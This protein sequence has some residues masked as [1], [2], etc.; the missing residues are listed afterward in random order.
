MKANAGHAEPGAGF[1]GLLKLV[2]GLS[3]AESAPN[4]QLN[5]LNPHITHSQRIAN[6]GWPRE[7]ASFG[8]GAYTGGVS[9]F[10]YSGTIAHTVL[11]R[12]LVMGDGPEPRSQAEF[13]RRSFV[14]CEPQHPF[15]Q[16]ML[17]AS[18]NGG[19]MFRSPATSALHVLIADHVIQGRTIFP[20]AGYL[21]LARA[22]C[23][24]ALLSYGTGLQHV[25]FLQPLAAEKA[26]VIESAVNG[27][28]FEIRS[29]DADVLERGEALTHCTGEVQPALEVP[30]AASTVGLASRRGQCERMVSGT[31]Q[32][33]EFHTAGLEYGP[34]YRK[35]QR[36]W[37]HAGAAGGALAQL[38]G[39]ARVLGVAVHPAELDGAVQLGAV[40]TPLGAGGQAAT[41]LPF[42]VDDAVLRGSTPRAYAV[43]FSPL[44][45]GA[46]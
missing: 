16:C 34:S 8:Q 20:G 38:Q 32:Y 35:L 31:A 9:S 18:T 46:W 11:R 39:S 22:A 26:E 30:R 2:V 45:C 36:L 25:F 33:Y 43:S 37:A 27:S 29:G 4:A 15:M 19:S 23:E 6:V 7:L 14:W 17:P 10:G 21:E 24:T 3:H 44:G 41:R 13:K 40:L 12:M 5:V 42:A 28:R 1:S